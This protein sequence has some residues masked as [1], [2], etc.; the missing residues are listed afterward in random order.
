MSC[1]GATPREYIAKSCSAPRVSGE[2][3]LALAVGVGA[4][5]ASTCIPS[6]PSISVWPFCCG[7]DVVSSI[8]AFQPSISGGSPSD[9]ALSS[10]WRGALPGASAV[11]ARFLPFA[12][13]EAAAVSRAG[14]RSRS[15]LGSIEVSEE[16]SEKSNKF[17]TGV[18]SRLTRSN[19]LSIALVCQQDA[20]RGSA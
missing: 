13:E 17:C 1:E 10:R 6:C 5:G 3:L 8:C 2:T 18:V 4:A 15:G 16:E 11:S 9:I 14:P 20:A 12:N 7:F 19:G